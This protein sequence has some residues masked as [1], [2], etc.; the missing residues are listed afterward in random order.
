MGIIEGTVNYFILKEEYTEEDIFL[1]LETGLYKSIPLSSYKEILRVLSSRDTYILLAGDLEVTHKVGSLD[2]LT[3]C[4]CKLGDLG[5]MGKVQESLAFITE[6]FT[7]D[8]A[9]KTNKGVYS[10]DIVNEAKPYVKKFLDIL[11]YLF[12]Y[13]SE[14]HDKKAYYYTQMIRGYYQKV[15]KGFTSDGKSV[16]S[17]LITMAV[18]YK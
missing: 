10:G 1:L 5:F 2:E 11:D 17:E 8:L 3:D 15:D 14:L 6:G 12:G 9:N 13:G 16:G 7:E 4:I 18:Y